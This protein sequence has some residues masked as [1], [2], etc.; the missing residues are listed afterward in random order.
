MFVG[1]T[2]LTSTGECTR[3]ICL[4]LCSVS[5]QVVSAHASTPGGP[6]TA[7]NLVLIRSEEH[8]RPTHDT[9]VS[10]QGPPPSTAA[11]RVP[12]AATQGTLSSE[13]GRA[14]HQAVLAPGTCSRS[15]TAQPHS[16]C[17]S[18]ATARREAVPPALTPARPQVL[19]LA[20]SGD[21]LL[22]QSRAS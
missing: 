16:S 11:V 4:V 22:G 1:Y 5:L 15:C 10:P 12:A 17:P 8:E 13:A 3:S 21:A 14:S 18:R 6:V 20:I 2:L 19:M 7:G 9:K